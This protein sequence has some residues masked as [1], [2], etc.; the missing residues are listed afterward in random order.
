MDEL[1]VGVAGGPFVAEL[2]PE[3]VDL[4]VVGPCLLGCSELGGDGDLLAEERFERFGE[5]ARDLVGVVDPE[6][7]EDGLV[8]L[9]TQRRAGCEVGAFPVDGEVDGSGEVRLDRLEADVDRC[10]SLF[11]C[12]Q[13]TGDAV[14]FD[15]EEVERDRV[16]VVGIEELLALVGEVADAASLEG[17]FGLGVTLLLLQLVEDEVSE[18]IEELL[19]WLHGPVVVLDEGFGFFD[20]DCRLRAVGAL[21]LSA[22]A[23]EV[24]VDGPVSALGVADHEAGSAGA[25]EEAALQVV[26]VLALLLAGAALLCE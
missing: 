1:A 8:E 9:S 23:D 19:R 26:M 15:L 11:G 2:S 25:A 6:L 7:L 10:Q 24:R 22:H 21:L 13:L 4:V 14:L 17:P 12:G 20:G 3:S 5:L 16:G 18:V